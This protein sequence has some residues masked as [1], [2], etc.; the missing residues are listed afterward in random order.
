MNLPCDY[1]SSISVC[2]K[3]QILS[4]PV[5][6]RSPILYVNVSKFYLHSELKITLVLLE[7]TIKSLT[8]I[9]TLCCINEGFIAYQAVY[10]RLRMEGDV[11]CVL[12]NGVPYF[13]GHGTRL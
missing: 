8:L 9:S 5:T 13:Q 7:V 10:L 11:T 3:K 12:A 4:L 6:G 1:L 2:Y